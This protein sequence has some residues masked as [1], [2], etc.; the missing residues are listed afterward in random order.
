MAETL[1]VEVRENLGK[2]NTRRLRAAG[3]VPAILYGHGQPNV[4]LAIQADQLQATVRHGSRVVNLT[5]GLTERA[6]LRDLQWD[7]FGLEILHVDLARISEHEMVTVTVAVELRGEAPGVRNGG[8]IQH[9]IHEVEMECEV[10]AIPDKLHVNVNHLEL[11][12]AIKV[13]DLKLPEGAKIDLDPEDIVVQCVEP[14]VEEEEA[15]AEAG[16]AEPEIIGRK[17]EEESEE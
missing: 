16:A 9:M 14:A 5:G 7:V 15:S 10:T 6:F 13:S 4:C 11:G 8:V 2:R 3:E 1:A 17:K 12:S